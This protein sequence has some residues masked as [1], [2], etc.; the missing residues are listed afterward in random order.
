MMRASRSLSGGDGLDL[1]GID[2]A[3]QSRHAYARLC[4]RFGDRHR[5]RLARRDR[6]DARLVRFER[7]GDRAKRCH[8]HAGDAEFVSRIIDISRRASIAPHGFVAIFHVSPRYERAATPAGALRLVAFSGCAHVERVQHVDARLDP[9]DEC[10]RLAHAR[11]IREHRIAMQ[12]ESPRYRADA[13]AIRRLDNPLSFLCR[14]DHVD[15]SR[16]RSTTLRGHDT[17]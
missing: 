9:F 6:S 15:F 3:A 17:E 13:V 10:A 8:D 4:R 12:I 5:R 7:V 14:R 1:A 2:R 11:A 16:V